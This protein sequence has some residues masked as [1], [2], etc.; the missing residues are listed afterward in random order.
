MVE[1]TAG[2][3]RGRPFGT[4]GMRRCAEGAL[5]GLRILAIEGKSLVAKGLKLQQETLG[6]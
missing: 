4:P 6:H 5:P 1:L 3:V 2:R